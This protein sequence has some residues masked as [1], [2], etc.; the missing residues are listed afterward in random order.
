A[1]VAKPSGAPLPVPAGAT[2]AWTGMYRVE[3]PY[4][5]RASIAAIDPRGTRIW[6]VDQNRTLN[7]MTPDGYK[8]FP[9]AQL[10]G[11]ANIDALVVGYEYVY[12]LDRAGVQLYQVSLATELLTWQSVGLLRDGIGF[13]VTPNDVLWFGRN[14]QLISYDPRTKRIAVVGTGASAITAVTTDSAARVWFAGGRDV[15]G[16]YDTR[17]ARLT[18]YVLPRRGAA[19]ALAVD[20][21]GSLW[22]ATDGGELFSLSDGVLQ[23]SARAAAGTTFSVSRGG[24][25]WTLRNGPAGGLYAPVDGS[26]TVDVVPGSVGALIFDQSGRAWLL[27]RTS[28]V[29]YAT[30]AAP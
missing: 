14:D 19:T 15:V 17:T 25:A 4:G 26:R 13:S 22:V 30:V 5:K 3:L 21:R 24:T 18:E 2:L 16:A 1:A 12:A 20:G 11:G 9:I 10:P 28:G 23:L 7:A 27:D 6:F 29:F 8:V